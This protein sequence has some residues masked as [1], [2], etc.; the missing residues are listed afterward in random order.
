MQADYYPLKKSWINSKLSLNLKKKNYTFWTAVKN[1]Q[2]IILDGLAIGLI[3]LTMLNN[4]TAFLF[5][6]SSFYII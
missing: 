5:D 4:A 6:S 2:V 1:K 3:S